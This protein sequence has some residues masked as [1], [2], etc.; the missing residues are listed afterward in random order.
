M[1]RPTSQVQCENITRASG[2][3]VLGFRL[4]AEQLTQVATQ[5]KQ[6]GS[7]IVLQL[8]HDPVQL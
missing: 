2:S 3:Q 6:L 5:S 1:P 8:V 7:V 4:V